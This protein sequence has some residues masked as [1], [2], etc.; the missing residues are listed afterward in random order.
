MRDLMV[1]LRTVA[2]NTNEI[3]SLVGARI[4]VN[5]I[6]REEVEEADT[7]HPPKI[8]VIRN[9]GGG[10]KQDVLPLVD[11]TVITLCY[12]ETDEEADK[13]LRAVYQRFTLLMRELH[14][15]VLIHHI[16]PTGGIIPSVEPDLVW[17]VLAQSY[18]VKAG[19]LEVR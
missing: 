12:G 19:L 1:A 17:P 14:E 11:S 8:L 2:I 9:G 5:E 7:R 4:H 13:V 16:N 18:T 10:A 3:F 6:P 15:G